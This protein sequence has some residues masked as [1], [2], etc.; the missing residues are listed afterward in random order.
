VSHA[1]IPVLIL[2]D[3]ITVTKNVGSLSSVGFETEITLQLIK[4]LT[5]SHSFGFTNALFKKTNASQGGQQ[6]ELRGKHQVFTPRTTS[7][8]HLRYQHYLNDKKN[9]KFEISAQWYCIGKQYFD[10]ANTIEQTSY[11]LFNANAGIVVKKFSVFVWGK[12]VTDNK[13]IDYA[14]DFGAVH[15]GNPAT[16]GIG[17][18]AAF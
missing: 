16:F 4:G 7:F 9:F 17:A 8:L 3:A 14:Y 5:L 1:Q 11:N 12:N 2:L 15:L 10:I 6:I 13:F 18:A